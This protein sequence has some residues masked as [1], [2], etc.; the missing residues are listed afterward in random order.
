MNYIN[1]FG[2]M[3]IHLFKEEKER[4]REYHWHCYCQESHCLFDA[5]EEVNVWQ[6]LLYQIAILYVMHNETLW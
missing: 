6:A 2:V 3:T 1:M 5:G 4:E